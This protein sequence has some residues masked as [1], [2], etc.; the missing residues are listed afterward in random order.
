MDVHRVA[1]P[2][3]PLDAAEALVRRAL[4]EI[5]ERY[6]LEAEPFLTRLAEIEGMREYR[7]F[8]TDAD[9]APT[10]SSTDR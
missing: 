2:N 7:Y 5:Q 3:A 8:L 6:R 4:A 9:P 1:V 10:A